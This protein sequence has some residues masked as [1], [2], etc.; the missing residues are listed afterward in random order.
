MAHLPYVNGASQAACVTST[1]HWPGQDEACSPFDSFWT[2]R[3]WSAS[4]ASSRFPAAGSPSCAALCCAGCSHQL[5]WDLPPVCHP[6]HA[7]VCSASSHMCCTINSRPSL[8]GQQ[9]Y[10]MAA[11]WRGRKGEATCSLCTSLTAASMRW[12][13]LAGLQLKLMPRSPCSW[14]LGPGACTPKNGDTDTLYT[15]NCTPTKQL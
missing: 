12:C 13:V 6:D 7:E 11:S 5:L 9:R 14:G 3:C 2:C 15:C 8:T 4:P 10:H 1:G